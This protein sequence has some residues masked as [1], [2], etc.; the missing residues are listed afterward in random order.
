MRNLVML[1]SV[2]FLFLGGCSYSHSEVGKR[3]NFVEDKDD[4]LLAKKSL[5][6]IAS[7]EFDSLK[8]LFSN[9]ILK[10]VSTKQMEWILKNGKKVIDNNQYPSDSVI[11]ISAITRK[12][13]FGIETYK[14]FIFP[15][16]NVRNSDSTASFKIDIEHG[17]I[18]KLML[19]T[20][21]RII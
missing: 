17:K 8:N 15:F 4:L 7:N 5:H 10:I 1:A 19:T 21:M 11:T 9:K 13:I 20:G 12:S 3:V 18:N 14:E 16:I 6:F 2:F